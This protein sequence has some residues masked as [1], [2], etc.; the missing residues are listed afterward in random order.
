VL[1]ARYRRALG[2]DVGDEVMI[3]LEGEELRLF[4]RRKAIRDA[5]ALIR[6]YVPAGRSLVDELIE[7]RRREME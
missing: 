1:P 6:R 3:R 4:T 5:Q 2:I 7:E